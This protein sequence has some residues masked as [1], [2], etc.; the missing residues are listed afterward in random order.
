MISRSFVKYNFIYLWKVIIYG[1]KVLHME[2]FTFV[3]ATSDNVI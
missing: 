3:I 1:L 2:Q